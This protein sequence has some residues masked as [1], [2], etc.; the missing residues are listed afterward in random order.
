MDN[1]ITTLSHD[2]SS[3]L[4]TKT[5]TECSITKEN[6]RI[7]AEKGFTQLQQALG[8]NNIN[9]GD[10]LI[11]FNSQDGTDTDT[12]TSYF[13]LAITMIDM[14]KEG[15][16]EIGDDIFDKLFKFVVSEYNKKL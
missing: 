1:T 14:N 7:L 12:L 5:T 9:A 16:D 8:R 2:I 4:Q 3:S 15:L 10:A 11:A 13:C 6:I